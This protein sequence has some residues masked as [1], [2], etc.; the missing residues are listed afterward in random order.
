MATLQGREEL[1]LLHRVGA[2]ARQLFAMTAW[3]V[4]EVAV[5][6]VLLG[7][8]AAAPIVVAVSNALTGTRRPFIPGLSVALIIGVVGALAALAVFIP[9]TRMLAKRGEA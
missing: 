8:G 1:N 5:V 2:T 4:A 3:E 6:G 9:T 7:A